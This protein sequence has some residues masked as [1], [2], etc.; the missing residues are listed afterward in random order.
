MKKIFDV[1]IPFSEFGSSRAESTLH[2]NDM[3]CIDFVIG[4]TIP[5]FYSGSVNFGYF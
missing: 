3:H 4:H 2:P 5:V 1:H